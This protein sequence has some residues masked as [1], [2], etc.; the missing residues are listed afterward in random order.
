MRFV[1]DESVD[2][3]IVEELRLAGHEVLYIAEVE[4]GVV[5]EIVLARSTGWGAVL[6]TAD[7]DFGE[8]VF[9]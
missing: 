4:P 7:K 6:V 2:R 3:Q 1:A 5:D 8:M 9:R